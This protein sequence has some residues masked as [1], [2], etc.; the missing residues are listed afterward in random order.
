[1]GGSICFFHCGALRDFGN[2]REQ[3]V[4]CT[5]CAHIIGG[6]T[7]FTQETRGLRQRFFFK[8]CRAE[9]LPISLDALA[10]A[11]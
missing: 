1:M 5:G 11:S 7:P 9:I 6:G 3:S 10:S 4:A 2:F 8:K